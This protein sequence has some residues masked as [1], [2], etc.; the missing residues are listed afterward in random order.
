MIKHQLE[1]ILGFEL[2]ATENPDFGDYSSNVAL[3]HKLPR[4]FAEK[5]VEKLKANKESIQV[6]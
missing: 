5:E 2:S 6:G 4:E 3:S 1:K